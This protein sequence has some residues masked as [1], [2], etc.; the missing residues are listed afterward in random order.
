MKQLALTLCAV[1]V[2]MSCAGKTVS[3]GKQKEIALA[4]LQQGI[5]F[6]NT[7]K[8][9]MALKKLLEAEKTIPDNA[10]LHNTLGLVYLAK[11]RPDLALLHLKTA[12]KINPDFIE[13][14][15]NLGAVYLKTQ[16]WEDAIQIF[17]EVS[18]NLLYATPEIPFSNLGWAYYQQKKY[19]K[20]KS[21]FL[22]ALDINPGYLVPAHGLASV[23]I[24]T[25]YQ[26]QAIDFL[27]RML[28][29]FPDAAILHSDMA[30]AYASVKRFDQ[31]KRSW[32]VVLK[33]EPDH[34]P[35]AKEAQKRLF[36]LQ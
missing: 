21:Y 32:Q 24:E 18:Q 22:K 1:L 3:T 30:K 33:L 28:Q 34:S 8:Y 23:F 17:E 7:G 20:A 2:C 19:E 25:G 14:K 26:Y 27:K 16:Q 5:E 10:D 13:A 6:Y 12:T 9:I 29:K 35:L 15:N 36:E 31:A 11:E 4:T